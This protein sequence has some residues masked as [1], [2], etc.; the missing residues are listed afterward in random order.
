LSIQNGGSVIV[1]W[2][3]P[4]I[5]EWRCGE[6]PVH[7]DAACLLSCYHYWDTVVE[8]YI[9]IPQLT[10]LNW[11]YYNLRIFYL[12]HYSQIYY[13]NPLADLLTISF[14]DKLLWHKTN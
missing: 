4:A 13:P 6:D 5:V 10:R 2:L 11:L 1:L 8:L 3:F 14:G 12:H 9:F 7:Y